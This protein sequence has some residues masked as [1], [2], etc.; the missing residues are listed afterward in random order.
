MMLNH[1]KHNENVLSLKNISYLYSAIYPPRLFGCTF[2]TVIWLVV[3]VQQ[4]ENSSHMKL[5]TARVS[6][7]SVIH[8]MI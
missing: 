4:R 7:S 1:F 5:L 2:C 8:V 6:G 3:V